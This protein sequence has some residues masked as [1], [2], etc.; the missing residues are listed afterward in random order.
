MEIKE[1]KL[2]PIGKVVNAS[3]PFQIKIDDTFCQG[4]KHLELFSHVH[5]FWWADKHDNE[6]D[7]STLVT[8]LPYANNVTAGVFACRAPYRP[9][10]IAV[11]TCP[12][13]NIDQNNGMIELAYID[14]E[15]NTPVLDIKPYIP[16]S[17]RI[18]E[19][20]TAYWFDNWPEWMED[21]ASFFT[22]HE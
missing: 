3:Y 2:F 5:I 22:E 16:V 7:R 15:L 19:V 9:N 8:D 17:D 1:L 14:A 11:T 12:I 10:P 18:K 13:V 6:K 20:K 4:L 21:A